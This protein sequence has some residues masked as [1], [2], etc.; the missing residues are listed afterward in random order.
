VKQNG[1][2]AWIGD[3]SHRCVNAGELLQE[4]QREMKE[5]EGESQEQRR[6]KG[7]AVASQ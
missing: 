7:R 4:R 2:S 3:M 5:S 6:V 1:E